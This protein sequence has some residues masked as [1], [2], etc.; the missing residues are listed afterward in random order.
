ATGGTGGATGGTG[1][2]TGGTGGGGSLGCTGTSVAGKDIGGTCY[3][4]A[5]KTGLQHGAAKSAC[6]SL[7]AGWDLCTSAKLCNPAVYTYLGTA[8]CNCNGGNAACACGTT[9]NLYIHVTDNPSA[10]Y[11]IRTSNVP[12]CDWASDACTNSVSETCGAA[13]CCR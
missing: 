10:P 2:A 11:Y 13:L 3:F 8:G 12:N 1:G 6:T 5:N 9:N 4:M 7:G